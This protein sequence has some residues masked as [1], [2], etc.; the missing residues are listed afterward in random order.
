MHLP[1]GS[2]FHRPARSFSYYHSSFACFTCRHPNRVGQSRHTSGDDMGRGKGI[3]S[4]R[5]YIRS[6][7]PL[8]LSDSAWW[9]NDHIE[10]QILLEQRGGAREA[11]KIPNC[12]F[13]TTNILRTSIGLLVNIRGHLTGI[14]V[15]SHCLNHTK[16]DIAH[17]RICTYPS[18][19]RGGMTW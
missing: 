15:P 6:E 1:R 4:P 14:L 16:C 3:T 18:C 17:G 2:D 19:G 13:R 7:F 8:L 5:S 9:K 10:F 12:S 11:L